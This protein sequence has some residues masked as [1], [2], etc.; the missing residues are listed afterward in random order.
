HGTASR[1]TGGDQLAIVTATEAAGTAIDKQRRI[2]FGRL[3]NGGQQ[4]FQ[5][6]FGQCI[7]LAVVQRNFGYA[8]GNRQCQPAHAS[9]PARASSRNTRRS[10]LPT[11]DLG[12]SSRIST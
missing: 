2:G 4:I 5:H 11:V 10:S 8:V 3:G 9:T 1:A 6:L 12:R 7:D